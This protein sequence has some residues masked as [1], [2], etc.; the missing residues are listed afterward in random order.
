MCHKQVRW[1]SLSY[2]R[3]KRERAKTTCDDDNYNEFASSQSETTSCNDW[4]ADVDHTKMGS[5]FWWFKGKG[6][7]S[8]V[9]SRCVTYIF[10]LVCVLRS[11]W[12]LV[13]FLKVGCWS[14]TRTQHHCESY[15]MLFRDSGF[16]RQSTNLIQRFVCSRAIN[17]AFL[18][19][20]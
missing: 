11:R 3:K 13:W 12:S 2:E 7:G 16:E 14:H 4:R 9:T 20:D 15:G 8:K 5:L 19:S 1:H 17:L 6:Q 18:N 10:Q